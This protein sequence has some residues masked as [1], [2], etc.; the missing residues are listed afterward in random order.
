MEMKTL[1][2]ISSIVRS[3]ALFSVIVAIGV[4]F[5]YYYDNESPN[6]ALLF[7][8]S[9]LVQDWVK[10]PI[11][12][13]SYSR[14]EL[15]LTSFFIFKKKYLFANIQKIRSSDSNSITFTMKSSLSSM[16]NGEE[17]SINL[18]EYNEREFKP[19]LKVLD[20]LIEDEKS[21]GGHNTPIR[22]ML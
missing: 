15:V 10:H 6:I 2:S 13:F 21:R 16:E 11:K 7:F 9:F 20:K 17:F 12:M 22:A 18:E 8:L 3:I 1:Y 5:I 14:N 19:F 4:A